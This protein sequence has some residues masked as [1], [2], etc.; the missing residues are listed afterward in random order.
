MKRVN[1]E[2]LPWVEWTSPQ[3]AFR[4]RSKEVSVALGAVPHAHRGAGGHPFDLEA[5]RLAPGEIGCPFHRHLAQWELFVFTA[6][7]GTVRHGHELREV[8]A[9]DGVLHP[10][11]AA[12]SLRNTGT[13]NLDYLLIADN[14]PL[15][16]V[17]YP[18]S[19]KWGFHPD[20]GFY[21]PDYVDYW[22]GEEEGGPTGT[23]PP[24]GPS[25]AASRFLRIDDLPWQRWSSP[26]GKYDSSYRDIS[27]ALGG[28]RDVGTWAGGHPF[29]LQ[30]R[31]V[32]PGA[33]ICPLHAHTVQWEL[34]VAVAGTATVRTLEGLTP[35]R[36]GDVVLQTPGTAHQIINTGTDDFIV[37]VIADH[38]PA[39]ST[40]YPDSQKW[41]LKP[42]R[43]IF[44]M[45]ETDYFDGEG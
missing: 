30:M 36:P 38:S 20:G 15:D 39:D 18:D 40:W 16:V 13:E 8:A 6:G 23:M 26:S 28:I 12:H 17:H 3:G 32:P 25:F 10:P 41:N 42:Q 9:G 7:T 21:R 43:K 1:L 14:P 45:T 34:F 31:K 33:A 11:G 27:F 22:H 2:E 35:V 5:G 4:G 19:G 29:D 24:A 37:H 44:R